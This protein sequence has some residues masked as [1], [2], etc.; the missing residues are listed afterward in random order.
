ML[1][2]SLRNYVSFDR[3]AY[4]KTRQASYDTTGYATAVTRKS[5]SNAP[6]AMS[7]QGSAADYLVR[8]VT[9]D[10]FIFQ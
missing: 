5:R 10:A 3:I 1:Y 2:L 9:D 4:F 7:P 8:E 6:I